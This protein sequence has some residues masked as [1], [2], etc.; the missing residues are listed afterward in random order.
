MNWREITKT[1]A[2]TLSGVLPPPFNVLASVAVKTV[3]G[4]SDKATDKDVEQ[5]LIS[6]SPEILQKLKEAENKFL[7][8]ME[9]LGVDLERISAND[10]D[11][12][13]KRE[14]EVKDKMPAILSVLIILCAFILFGF[15]LSGKLLL[16]GQEG[17]MVGT[18]V[19]FAGGYVTQVMNYYFGSTTGS[20]RKTELMAK[21]KIGN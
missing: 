2:P 8:D 18:I 9:S 17:L 21:Q 14:E 10:R 3:L 16:T 12:A 20:A 4:M 6:A 5:A 13:R 19:G 7:T 15:A 1:I 11:S